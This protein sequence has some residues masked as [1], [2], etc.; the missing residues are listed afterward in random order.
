MDAALLLFAERGFDGTT[1]PAIAEKANVGAGTIYR[2]FDSKETLVNVV[3]QQCV[4]LFTDSIKKDF[5]YSSSDLREKF[6]HVWYG[7]VRFAKDNIH[8]LYFIDTHKNARSLDPASREVLG[9]LLGFFRTF[10]EE[11]KQRNLI[12]PLP[13]EALIAIV[14]GAFLSVYE[15]VRAEKLP[16]TRELIAG[17]EE[18]CWDAIRV[19]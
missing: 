5:P 16:E 7:M 13:S 2:Y 4:T 6:Q 3:F 18:C 10:L 19:H 1:V 9:Q 15:S 11:G 14:F 17:I 8:A 12:R